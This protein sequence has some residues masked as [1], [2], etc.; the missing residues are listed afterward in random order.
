MSPLFSENLPNNYCRCWYRQERIGLRDKQLWLAAFSTG[1][2]IT[3]KRG[4][5]ILL[6]FSFFVLKYQ[7]SK[8]PRI[9]AALVQFDCENMHS[10]GQKW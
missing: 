10:F 8:A 1:V 6:N 4:V 5:Q 9:H 3:L 7:D 2:H